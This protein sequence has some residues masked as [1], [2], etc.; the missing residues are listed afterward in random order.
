[1]CISKVVIEQYCTCVYVWKLHVHVHVHMCI[2][3]C[4]DPSLVGAGTGRGGWPNVVWVVKLVPVQAPSR[5][6]LWW[7]IAI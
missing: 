7:Q 4:I 6:G 2:H 3:V 5:L 1:M